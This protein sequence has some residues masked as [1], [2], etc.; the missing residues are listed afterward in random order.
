MDHIEIAIERDKN[1]DGAIF[2]RFQIN[3]DDLPGILNIEAF[4][5]INQ[6]NEFVPLFTCG[7]G[8]FGCGG[9]YVSIS[10]T[11]TALILQNSYHRF[12]HYLESEFEYQLDWQQ[13]RNIAEEIITYLEKIQARNSKTIVTSGY[14][15]INLIEYI[16]D[17]R[18]SFLIVPR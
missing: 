13:V 14:G 1:D 2:V 16:P 12:N 15:P 18:Q 3:G 10:Y 9:Y 8:D 4:F 7:C 6:E 11:D 5:A 17:F